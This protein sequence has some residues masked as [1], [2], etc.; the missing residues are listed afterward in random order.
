MRKL[1]LIFS[2][3]AMPVMGA[4]Q[5]SI[6]ASSVTDS[7]QHSTTL[8]RLCF[9]PVDATMTPQ[10]FRYGTTQVL[11]TETCGTV[12]LGVLQSGLTV[13]P[14]PTGINY[15][16]YVKAS[17]SNTILRDFGMVHITGSSWTLDTYDPNMAILPV[18]T[19]QAG[20]FTTAPAGTGASCTITGSGAGPFLLNCS[21]PQGVAGP[22]GSNTP[23][24]T[25][26]STL[27]GTDFGAKLNACVGLQS[28][29]YGGICE[30]RAL[31]YGALATS[32]AL[33]INTPNTVV[34]LPCATITT[35]QQIIVPAGVRNVTFHG[36]G[37][38][39]GSA[40]SGTAGGTVWVY[41]GSGPAFK[42][43]DPTYAVD[44]KGFHMD[45]VNVNTAN[46][47]TAAGAFAFYRTQEI[48]LRNLYLNGNQL[49]GQ[50]GILLDGTGNYSGG[51]FDSDTMNGYGAGVYMTGHLT[52]SAIGDY[53]NA[54]TFTRLHI[55]CPTSS[56]NPITGTFGINI[57]AGDG[58]TWA[59]G[60]VEGCDT[61]FHLGANAVNNTV[62]GLRNENS[63][64]Q[65]L[66]DS[67]SSY[68][69]VVT[70]GTFYT[71]RLVDN[72]SRNSFEDAFHFA[73]NGMKGDWYAS[74]QDAT[75]VNHLRLGIGTGT[76][77]GLQWETQVDQGTSGSQ[78]NWLWGLTDGASGQSNWIYQ[79][80]INNVIR[81]QFQQYNTAGGS[82]PTAINGAGTGNVC[83]NC[84]ANSGTGGF[85][86]ASGGAT[87]TAVASIDGSGNTT[88]AG[89]LNLMG[90]FTAYSNVKAMNA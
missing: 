86:V 53:A 60:D 79:D 26:L 14:N 67:G 42:V 3:L 59:G 77:R 90:V 13:A 39:G 16:V 7:F 17:N 64:T 19:I 70:G 85:A 49:T 61:M 10:G 18:S 31:S 28:G 57:V 41:T 23:G 21:V 74:Q 9:T 24:G 32:S 52:G 46:A 66:A 38:Q 45:N 83:V 15:H 12:T 80:L 87:P 69:K 44:T 1:I 27:A 75:V 68:N 76:V 29:T 89:A 84:S 33:T 2:L 47:G 56:G 37:F 71:G 48:D 78:Y 20:T 50:T 55:A 34:Y 54:S 72:G 63:N 25:D 36:C 62:D 73:H 35:A 30:G 58:N 51:T 6:S 22:G 4:A 81:L 40:A 11:P 82:N 5:V 43:G 88:L 65:Y 8:S